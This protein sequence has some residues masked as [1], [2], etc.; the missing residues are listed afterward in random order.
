METGPSFYS[1]EIIR[2]ERR[3]PKANEVET[4]VI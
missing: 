2:V 3:E 1:A 4:Q